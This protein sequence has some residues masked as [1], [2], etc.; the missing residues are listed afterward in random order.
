[1]NPANFFRW[2]GN[3]LTSGQAGAQ[4]ARRRAPRHPSRE[5]THRHGT[6]RGHPPTP[7]YKLARRFWPGLTRAQVL[8]KLAGAL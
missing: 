6:R 5:N 4:T 1:M 2:L 8:A 3:M 7:G